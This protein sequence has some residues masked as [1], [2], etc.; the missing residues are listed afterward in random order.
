VLNNPEEQNS[1][2]TVQERETLDVPLTINELDES[3]TNCNPRSAVGGDGFSNTLIKKCWRFLRIPLFNYANHCFRT[4]ILTPGFRSACIKLIPKKGDQTK[5]KNWRPISLLSNMYKI[6]SR[7]INARL[8]KIV[9][10]IC[11]RA[12]KGYNSER[13]VQEVLINVVE[14]I[15]HCKSNNLRGAVL[16]VDM[17]KAFDS[18]NHDFIAAVYRFFGL[19]DNIIKWLQL[20]GNSR[21]ASIMLNRGKSTPTFAIETGSAQGDNPS[22][23]IFTVISVSKF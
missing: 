2:L 1:K 18:L 8:K 13:Y 14:T 5:L 3:L 12:Q 20:L 6:L 9:N 17:A 11:S 16:A 10:R 22:P 4:G 23:N 7:T 19:G 15:A 21:L